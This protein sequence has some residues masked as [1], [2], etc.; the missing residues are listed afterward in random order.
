MSKTAFLFP[1]QGAQIAGMGADFYENSPRSKEIF[2]LASEI[3]G[4]DMRKLCFQ[5]NDLLDITE[6]TQ[7]ALLTASLA[8]EE[9]VRGQGISP[10]VAAGLSLGEYNAIVSAKGMGPEDAM[11]VVRRRGMLMQEAV[12][13][14]EGAMA[15]VL[16]LEA[17]AIEQVL[18]EM[19]GVYIANYNCPGQIVITGYADAVAEAS[20]K[21]KNAGAKRV[22]PLN[23]SGPFHSP[24]MNSAAKGLREVL[25]GVNFGKLEIPYV[26]NVNAE[27][28]YDSQLT[29]DLLI[30]QVASSVRWQQSVEA[31]IADGVDTFVEIGPGRTLTGFLRKIDRS[32][33][34]YNIRTY[35]EMQQVC[36]TLAN[37]EE[38]R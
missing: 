33:T 35:E 11:K 34:C 24:M 8:M 30:R 21:L 15:A 31:M 17:S 27:Y 38:G 18:G 19:E 29:R 22:L 9:A 6:F 5:E 26:T 32:V 2:D 10:S 23:V 1:G 16:G 13:T 4:I 3:I 20:G 37:S 7:I 36:E 25:G 12:P 28:V 14:G